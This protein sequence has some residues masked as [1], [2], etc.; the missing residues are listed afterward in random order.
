M[1]DA[2]Y[3]ADNDGR[4]QI[5]VYPVPLEFRSR[6]KDILE[7]RRTLHRMNTPRLHTSSRYGEAAQTEDLF[8]DLVESMRFRVSLPSDAIIEFVSEE[9][10]TVTSLENERLLYEQKKA[11]RKPEE[12]PGGGPTLDAMHKW[13]DPSSD[14]WRYMFARNTHTSIRA[15]EKERL[16]AGKGTLAR[17][18]AELGE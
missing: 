16:G 1:P 3:A 18:M 10:Y 8:H 17:L 11:Q 15:Y 14:L 12:I 9:Q 5:V 13:P 4:P 6:L 7:R 2:P